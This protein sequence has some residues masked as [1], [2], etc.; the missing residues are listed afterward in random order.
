MRS[1]RRAILFITLLSSITSK[2]WASHLMGGEITWTCQGNGQFVFHMKLYR[3]C[4]GTTGPASANLDV[5]NNPNLTS[6][7]LNLVSQTDISPQCNAIGPQISC[8]NTNPGPGAVEEFVYQS[9]PIT[10]SGVPPAAG[11]I[12]A[13]QNCCRNAAITNLQNPSSLGFTLRAV[14]YPY[15]GQ[16]TNPCYDN[17]PQFLESPKTIICTG[18]PFT[19]N[20]NAVDA[21]LD[22]LSYAWA[23]PL[24]SYTSLPPAAFS[25]PLITFV[26]GFSY[27]DPMPDQSFNASNIPASMDPATG[28]ISYTSYTS[29]NF[30]TSIKVEAWKCGVHV[31][32]IYRDIQVV[33]LPCGNN[34]PPNVIPP[35]NGNTSFRD[36]VYAGAL[37]NFSLWA[38]DFDFLPNGQPQTLTIDATGQEFGAGFTNAA[39]GCINPPCATLT[40]PPPVSG[41]FGVST[42]FSWQTACNHIYYVN[43]CFQQSNTYNFVIH[44]TDDFCPAPA[45]TIS[46]ISITVL[47]LP[48]V[49]SPHIHC[50]AV[51]PNGDITLTWDQPLDTA[52][53]FDSYHIFTSANANGPFTELDSIFNY[54]QLSYTHVGANGNAAPVYYYITTRSG[55]GGMI[56]QPSQDTVSSM[57]LQVTNSNNVA[58]LL[59]W[60]NISVP[61]PTTQLPW[62]HIYREYPTGVW[63]LIDSTQ[64][65]NYVDSIQVCNN[66]INY[67]VEIGDSLGC[68]SIS[69]IDGDLFQDPIIPN[70]PVLDSTSV[71][72]TGTTSIGWAASTSQ[73]VIGYVVYQYINGIWTAID[74]LWGYNNTGYTNLISNAGLQSESYVIAA[75]DSCGNVSTFSQIHNT[76]YLQKQLNICNATTVLWWNNYINIPGG[77]GG[78][79]IFCSDNGGPWT[80]I[81]STPANDSIFTHSGLAQF[82]TYCYYVQAYNASN[83]ITASS[84]QVCVFANVPQQPVFNYLRVATVASSNV[85]NV[86]G[87]VDVAADVIRYDVYRADS[88]IG[89]WNLIGSVPANPLNSTVLFTDITPQTG[90]QSYFYKMIAIDSCG[91]NSM[92]SNIGRTIFLQAISNDEITN[93]LFWNDYEQWLGGVGQY[94]VYRAIDGTWDPAPIVTVPYSGA[95]ENIYTDDV[96]NYIQYI[97]KFSYEVEGIEGAGNPYGFTDT[98]ESNVAEVLQKPLVYV[99]NAFTPNNNG[100]NDMF[101]PSTGYVDIV[102]YDFAVFNRWGEKIYETDDRTQGWDG[103][104]GG[105]KCE[106][107]VYVWL[108]TFKTSSGQYIDQKGIVTLLR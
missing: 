97:G 35:F 107:G 59:T 39:G 81:G 50:V 57:Y 103:T 65:L 87:Y 68:S 74:T 34:T 76:L 71:T 104:Y 13:Y 83:T 19:Y 63:T 26:P 20:H 96:T 46:T 38:T 53:T 29:G 40:P 43:Q 100:L 9:N 61:A 11:W 7:S 10:I 27:T 93:T 86:T 91:N 1:L 88:I 6:I 80:L 64:S 98:T 24:D 89:P 36:T 12:F 54:N 5:F 55:C 106:R 102:D 44:V 48:L 60:N 90:Q 3:D 52:G 69:N 17:S 42:D 58:A 2:L 28:E 14:M 49:D 33:L 45:T 99:P 51:A 41:P 95:G 56:Y 18:F 78:Y 16:N 47:A 84:E 66:Q 72:T 22:S 31:A 8:S 77:L 94:N 37:V 32:D 101:M 79:N 82:H 21:E 73:D 15:N 70:I 4:N 30:V 85:V 67:Y 23:Q 62:F 75:F 108:L 25:A 105:H 92:V